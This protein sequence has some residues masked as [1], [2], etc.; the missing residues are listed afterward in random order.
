MLTDKRHDTLEAAR[1]ASTRGEHEA[2]VRLATHALAQAEAVHDGA[3]AAEAELLLSRGLFFL[4]R[5]A[6]CV[7]HARSARRRHLERG[8]AAQARAAL[9]VV[10]HGLTE[11]GELTQAMAAAREAFDDAEAQHRADEALQMMVLIGTLHGRLLAFHDAE[12]LLLQALSRARDLHRHDHEML[13]TS[14][15]LMVLHEASEA[16]ARDGRQSQA[17]AA[18]KHLER[19]ALH[20]NLLAHDETHPGRRAI[21]LGNAGE[22]LARCGRTQAAAQA[23]A[24]SLAL[25]RAQGMAVVELGALVRQGRLRLQVHDLDGATR[26]A[27]E[28]QQALQAHPHEEAH[29]DLQDLQAR[30]LRERGQD[31]EAAEL[32]REVARRRAEREQRAA[33]ARTALDLEA[34]VQALPARLHALE[35]GVQP[36]RG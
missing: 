21:G 28:L 7:Q 32:E 23:I 36:L 5:H 31:T 11:S 13:A 12:A 19:H 10:A 15:L 2:Q 25:A 17:E 16:H 8:D 14:A 26:S 34:E 35:T 22:A 18:A 30:I 4:G 1:Q 27:A 3:A 29:A 9:R 24:Q 6:A 33:A 20:L